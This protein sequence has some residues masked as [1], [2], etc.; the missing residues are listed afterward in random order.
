MVR[1]VG[2]V[3]RCAPIGMQHATLVGI[4]QQPAQQPRNGDGEFRSAVGRLRAQQPT[5]QAR[6]TPRNSDATLLPEK[7]R[8]VTAITPEQAAE[9]RRIVPEVCR[10]CGEADPDGALAIAL[11][12]PEAALT[13][14]RALL[15]ELTHADSTAGATANVRDDRRTCISCAN[16]SPGGL[17]H[18][19]W[20]GE[21]FGPGMAVARD[22][23]PAMTDRPQ[24]CLAYRPGPDESDRRIGRERWPWLRAEV[25]Q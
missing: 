7:L 6:N 8:A 3:A 15:P 17:C 19:A 24:R 16:L 23:A 1:L 20:R 21:S 10:L 25:N 9:L 13:C 2:G 18:A 4:A 22:W 5:Q 14:Y 12:D 11:A